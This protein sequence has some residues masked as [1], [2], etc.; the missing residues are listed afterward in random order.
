MFFSAAFVSSCGDD[1]D[2]KNPGEFTVSFNS[3]GGSDVA[4][5]KVVESGKA[6]KPANPTKDGFTFVAWYKDNNTFANEWNF[7]TEVVTADVT[8]FAKWEDI[9]PDFTVTFNSN[10]G[11]EVSE[12]T[13][14]KG[15]KAI[16]PTPDPTKDDNTFEGW[17]TDNNTFE[18]E[19]NFAVNTVTANVTLFAKWE[20][21]ILDF[22]VTF[23]SN[24]GSEVSGQIV[25]KG[26]KAIKPTP[27]PT[28]NEYT[29]DGWFRDN[30]TFKNEW[31]FDVNTVTANVTLF[32]KWVSWVNI[33]TDVL[34]NTSTPFATIGPEYTLPP[35]WFQVA[36]WTVSENL[37]TNGS[38][39]G[40]WRGFVLGMM[41]YPGNTP[42]R[43]VENGKIHQT[44]ELEAGTY[45]FDALLYGTT[46]ITK[47]YVAVALGK[48]LPDTDDIEQTAHKFVSIPS[49]AT[50]TRSFEFTLSAKTE[51]SLGF[52]GNINLNDDLNAHNVFF[53]GFTLWAWK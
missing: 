52:V 44:F 40:G 19:W 28:K 42:L 20:E 10:G 15:D 26:D 11:S 6:T 31:D 13:V 4:D 53:S 49:G 7:A 14:A 3:N 21:I 39:A 1:D 17:F 29:F 48:D 47:V 45:R 36:D 30:N 9:V 41:A 51:V 18:N 2:K 32:A 37:V 12:Q 5:Q 22:T 35:L 43:V 38:V 33:T 8:L 46:G 24:G 23:D 50:G 16:K 25:T 27:D 34:E